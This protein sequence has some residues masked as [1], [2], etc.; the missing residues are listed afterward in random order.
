MF[1]R[2]EMEAFT[3]VHQYL[4]PGPV[5]RCCTKNRWTLFLL[6]PSHTP[7]WQGQSCPGKHYCEPNSLH[8]VDICPRPFGRCPKASSSGLS[9]KSSTSPC[10]GW[11]L[12]TP[13]PAVWK[14]ITQRENSLCRLD[15]GNPACSPMI[16][17]VVLRA[18]QCPWWETGK[19]CSCPR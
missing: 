10:S 15:A 19:G 13:S 11:S 2:K 4:I 8:T 1:P 16:S 18:V 12:Q 17:P 3:I 14:W 9:I 6:H 5:I 7:W